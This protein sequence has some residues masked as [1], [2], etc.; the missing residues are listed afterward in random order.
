MAKTGKTAGVTAVKTSLKTSLKEGFEQGAKNVD[1]FKGLWT[2]IKTYGDNMI[3]QITTF[4]KP[5][6]NLRPSKIISNS[7]EALS[8]GLRHTDNVL[9]EATHNFRLNMGLDPQLVT[10][11]MSSGGGKLTHI[12]DNI[13]AFAK[14]LDGSVDDVAKGAKEAAEQTSK[15]ARQEFSEEASEQFAKHSDD[16][17]R[18]LEETSND[19][20]KPEISETEPRIGERR[21]SRDIYD[22]LRKKS[23]TPKIRRSVNEG[24]SFPIDDPAIPGKIVADSF[25]ADHIVSMDRITRMDGFDKLTREQQLELLNYRDNFEGL[26]KSANTSKGSKTYEEW[27]MYKKEGIPIDPEFRASMIAKEQELSRTLQGLIDFYVNQK[28]G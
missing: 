14:N 21:V 10:G 2:G 9:S 18:G 15:K 25:E 17:A 27:T 20:N 26:S 23:P 13:S 7:A 19:L 11:T 16:V 22:S 8:D 5:L 6:D 24:V 4:G 12:A 1:N 28:G 3:S